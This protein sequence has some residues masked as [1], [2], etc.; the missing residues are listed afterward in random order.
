[1]PRQ[2]GKPG[3][4][5]TSAELD[6]AV[7]ELERLAAD[8]NLIPGVHAYCDRWCERCPLTAR[9]LVFKTEQVDA[10]KLGRARRDAQNQDFWNTLARSFAVTRPMILRDAARRGID[11]EA[12]TAETAT[13]V[14]ERRRRRRVA[15][16]RSR[17]HRAAMSYSQAGQALLQR[18]EPELKAT[19]EALTTQA[20]LGAGNPDGEALAIREALE[21]VE[22]YLFFIDVKLERAIASRVDE[23]REASDGFP[24]DADGSAKVALLAIDC[25][26]AAWA[27][28]RTHLP[29]EADAM[30]DLLVMLER[31]RDIV[32]REFPRART[33]RR[34]GFD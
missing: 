11:L 17:V 3:K 10:A 26:I 8:G 12:A 33:F 7:D 24:S 34:P 16:E 13:L 15:R 28:L 18:L 1:M 31:L 19:G 32:E 20:R 22:W 14:E 5:P 30:L 21:I 9:C 25:S 23:L 27:R 4:R 29:A 6:A 2:P